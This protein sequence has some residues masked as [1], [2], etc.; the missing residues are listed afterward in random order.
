MYTNAHS[1]GNKQKELELCVK[2]ESYYIVEITEIWWDNSNDWNIVLEGYRLF[3][4]DRQGRRGGGITLHVKKN[5]ECMEWETLS[6][7]CSN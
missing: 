6:L 3:C 2:S 4:K 7:C 5:L 1:Q